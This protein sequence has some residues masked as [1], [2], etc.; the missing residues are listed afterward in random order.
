MTPKV[1]AA[2]ASQPKRCPC[3]GV[4][5]RPRKRK[6]LRA[7]ETGLPRGVFEAWTEGKAERG[8]DGRWTLRYAGNCSS[9]ITLKANDMERTFAARHVRCR[10]CPQCLRARTAYWALA[11]VQQTK[12]A[13]RTWF[14]TL[15][16][17]PE[18][19][20]GI[21]AAAMQSGKAPPDTDWWDAHCEAR[22]EAV[23]DQLLK[24]VQRFWKRLRK[25]GHKFS[26][27]VVFEQHKSGLPHVHF[28]L[29]EKDAQIR[30]KDI[31]AQ[32][33]FGFSNCS[34]VGGR[35]RQAAAPERAAW[36]VAKYLSKSPQARQVASLRYVP[37]A[38]IPTNPP[39]C[40]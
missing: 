20:D 11:A 2:E 13:N 28:L 19:Q 8:P 34:I 21:L 12:L 1:N 22:F 24:E 5:T 6:V 15:T 38:R 25:A 10:R 39:H 7:P 36:Y 3:G 18:C 27:L 35:S 23:R 33:P 30:K 40:P 31:Q 29:H 14:G 17:R 16:L 26:Y 32:W 4:H 37:E 9:P